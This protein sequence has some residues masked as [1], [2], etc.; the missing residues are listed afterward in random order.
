MDKLSIIDGY[1]RDLGVNV[2]VINYMREN[3]I[4]LG[5]K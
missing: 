4:Y 2:N 5:G 3:R 1:L